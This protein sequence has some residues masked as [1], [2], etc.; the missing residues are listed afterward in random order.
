MYTVFLISVYILAFLMGCLVGVI[1][2]Y[3]FVPNPA[4]DHITRTENIIAY[5]L[6]AMCSILFAYSYITRSAL[7]YPLL[8][9]AFIIFAISSSG[10]MVAIPFLPDEKTRQI[11]KMCMYVLSGLAV[12]N[13]VLVLYT[14]YQV[15]L[16][17]EAFLE[18]QFHA[19]SQIVGLSSPRVRRQYLVENRD[20]LWSKFIANN[21]ICERNAE[22]LEP[23]WSDA[24]A[25]ESYIRHQN[26]SE[27]AECLR[28]HYKKQNTREYARFTPRSIAVEEDPSL[29]IFEV[30]DI[31]D[32]SYV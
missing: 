25:F 3:V 29:P 12:L 26:N 20:I 7:P 9:H 19:L 5:A 2:K 1:V 23:L 18:Q 17:F 22:E 8:F 13:L 31:S 10:V 15:H 14:Y 11:E 6:L 4:N 27:I 32:V 30:P 24:E 21:K 28:E 16:H